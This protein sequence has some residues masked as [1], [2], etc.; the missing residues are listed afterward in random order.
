M[1]CAGEKFSIVDN[2]SFLS[3]VKMSES[4]LG[5]RTL[6]NLSAATFKRE[7]SEDIEIVCPIIALNF[8]LLEKLLTRSR[9]SVGIRKKFSLHK[10]LDSK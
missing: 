4:L 1:S 3:R 9:S 7:K 8:S 6:S 10:S 2:E 5:A